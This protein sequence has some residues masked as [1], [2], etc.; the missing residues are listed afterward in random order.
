MNTGKIHLRLGPKGEV[1]LL[2]L[3]E[4]RVGEEDLEEF[5]DVR[6]GLL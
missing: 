2:V 4:T 1:V 6:S 3:G 5:P